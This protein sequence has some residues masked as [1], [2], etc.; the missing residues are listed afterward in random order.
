MLRLSVL[1]VISLLAASPAGWAGYA[2]GVEAFARGDHARAAR[3]FLEDAQRGDAESA[4]MLGRLYA[5]GSGVPEDWVSSWLWHDR[6]VRLGHEE[7]KAARANMEA[8]L[9][10]SHLAQAR[11][12]A[13]QLA[14]PPPEVAVAPYETGAYIPEP[15]PIPVPRSTILIPRE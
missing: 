11:S 10:P 4:Y 14:G 13:T 15:P 1:T 7:A 3:E 9:H 8:I 2:E 12:Q 5:M 6:A